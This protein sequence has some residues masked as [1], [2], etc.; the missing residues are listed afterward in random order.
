MFRRKHRKI[1]NFAVLIEKEVTRIAEN[2]KVTKT[3]P[4][5]YNLLKSQYFWQAHYQILSIIFLKVFIE[6]NVN[7][8]TVTGNVKHAELNI[9]IASAFLNKQTLRMIQ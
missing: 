6:P 1:Y 5:Y 8:D 2:A 9:K 3:Y 7:T 4:K